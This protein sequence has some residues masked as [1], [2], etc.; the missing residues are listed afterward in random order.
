MQ[1]YK[2]DSIQKEKKRIFAYTYKIRLMKKYFLLSTFLFFCTLHVF[3]ISEVVKI[4]GD[5]GLLDA[6]IQ[7][8]MTTNEQKI[9][10]VII[11]HG[12]MGNK[13]EFLLRNVAD[14][15]EARGIASIRFDFNGHGNSEGEFEDMTV[16]NEIKDALQ[17]YYYVKV[18]PFIKNIGIVGHSQ[19]GVV[20]AMLSGQLTHEKISA[21][22]LLAPAAVLRDDCIRGNTMGA[23]YDP[24]NAPNGVKLFNGKKLGANYIRT[25]F[26]LPIY[27]TAINYQGPACIIHG[28][29]DKIVPYTYGQRF[30]YII[31]NSEFHLMDLMDHGFSKHE[32]EVAHLVANYM[33]KI[34]LSTTKSQKSINKKK[35]K[36]ESKLNPIGTE[37]LGGGYARD[38]NHAYY[39]GKIISDAWGGNQFIYKGDGYATDGIHTYFKGRPV[40]RD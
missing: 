35:K 25:A 9:P 16:P 28:N 11:C 33:Q 40:D 37:D 4:Q 12:F 29:K 38:K 17:V 15:L 22:A 32:Q 10:M 39:N 6:I 3:A 21:I 20:T 7:K 24:F 8:P 2:K 13:N 1:K 14:S 30:S 5:H 26:N 18:L 23:M 34:L 31:K 19:G 27:E 36:V